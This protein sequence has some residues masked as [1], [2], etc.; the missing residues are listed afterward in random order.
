ML[1]P[2]CRVQPSRSSYVPRRLLTL[3]QLPALTFSCP[4]LNATQYGPILSSTR[5]FSSPLD[6]S[7]LALALCFTSDLPPQTKVRSP[8]ALSRDAQPI[9]LRGNDP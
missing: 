7:M 2:T 4:S 9:F 3:T 5:I 6:G 8:A 1:I